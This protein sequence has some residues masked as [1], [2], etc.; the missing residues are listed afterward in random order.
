[1]NNRDTRNNENRTRAE[2]P[3]AE[4]PS[5][6]IV[7]PDRPAAP[8]PAKRVAPGRMTLGSMTRR[9]APPTPRPAAPTATA[10]TAPAGAPSAEAQAEETAR[11]RGWSWKRPPLDAMQKAAAKKVSPR[12]LVL[13]VAALVA[14]VVL[15]GMLFGGSREKGVIMTP[16]EQKMMNDYRNYL[17]RNGYSEAQITDRE[18]EVER[19]IKAAKLAMTVGEEGKANGEFRVLLLKDND[20]QSPLYKYCIEQFK[21]Q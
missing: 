21:K 18:R 3:R 17:A 16:A 12:T 8:G 19:R 10:A 2:G 11:K 1:M 4:P 7:V 20:R 13:G 15:L 5:R 6:R 9:E 14:A